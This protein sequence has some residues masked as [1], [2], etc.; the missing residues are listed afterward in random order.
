[1]CVCDNDLLQNFKR[2]NYKS[3]INKLLILNNK[4]KKAL[5]SNIKNTQ[6]KWKRRKQYANIYFRKKS[7]H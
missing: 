7:F 4:N 1:M 2:N 5:I 3:L 6:K